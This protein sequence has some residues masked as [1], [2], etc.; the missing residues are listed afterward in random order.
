MASSAT[1][2]PR[3]DTHSTRLDVIDTKHGRILCVADVRGAISSLNTL[4]AEHSAIAIIHT[5]DFGFYEPASIAH[6]SDRTLKHLV[7]YS[8]L[9]SPQLRS[10][11]LASTTSPAQLRHL[12]TSATTPDHFPLSE[13]PKLVSGQLQLAVPIYTVYGA[14][15]DV[16]VLE[17]IRLAG[18]S[19]LRVPTASTDPTSTTAALSAT[20]VTDSTTQSSYSIANLTVLDEATTRVLEIGG[21][22]LRLFGLGGAVVPHKLF[23]NGTGNATIAGGMGTMWTTMLQIGELVDTAQKVYDPTETRMLITHASPG[24]EGLVAQLALVL[25]SDLTVSG[26]LH[27]RYGSSYN[28]FSVT[29]DPEQ[30]RLK[31]EQSRK[32]FQG[33]WDAVQS[34]VEGVVD[35]H[36]KVLLANALAVANRVPASAPTQGGPAVEET[37]WKNCW[38]WNLP[39]ASFGS[40]V[41]DIREG[42]VGS[43]MK[44]QGFNFAYRS[45]SAQNSTP[46]AVATSAPTAV[47]GQ[48]SS[49]A[50]P[51]SSNAP[52]NQHVPP[53]GFAGR[54]GYHQHRGSSIRGNA[55]FANHAHHHHQQHQQPPPPA[56]TQQNTTASSSPP[57]A[58]QAVSNQ[59]SIPT[60]TTTEPEA[61]GNKK[62]ANGG[63]SSTTPG[64]RHGNSRPHSRNHPSS[65]AHQQ[66]LSGASA[67]TTTTTNGNDTSSEKA[68]ASPLPVTEASTGSREPPASSSSANPANES[69][70]TAAT[71]TN[72]EQQT[73]ESKPVGGGRGRGRGR[74][75][76]ERGTPRTGGGGRGRSNGEWRGSGRGG[77]ASARGGSARSNST[78]TANNEGGTP[79]KPE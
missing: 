76:G 74:G 58:S 68:P 49:T 7:Q 32:Q 51:S 64:G 36:Q 70:G 14:C 57:S 55:R 28:E 47:A 46:T 4:A 67:P 17:Q 8:S 44:S 3:V 60:T 19:P 42:R 11:L 65:Q 13:F 69:G 24:R 5:G 30:Y 31:L 54:G 56:P 35:E 39:D 79:S 77:A 66:P 73:P 40:L 22:K 12:L 63:S 78:T 38:N 45:S 9:I 71:T 43:E 61:I 52:Q 20:T 59:I 25:K 62:E 72:N 6:I 33:V 37:A 18:P 50:L 23:D 75:G 41:L 16:H 27:F 2:Q 21:L 1:V 15:E 10:Q 34:Q 29:W 48:P 26:G 53:Q